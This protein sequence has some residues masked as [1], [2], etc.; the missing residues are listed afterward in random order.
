MLFRRT[1]E[2]KVTPSWTSLSTAPRIGLAILMTLSLM[3]IQ[4]AW[5]DKVWL[6]PMR[7]TAA[8]SNWYPQA[9]QMRVGE[10][11]SLDA[12]QIS[13]RLAGDEKESLFAAHRV[14][15]IEPSQRSEKQTAAIELFDAQKYDESLRGLLDSLKERPPVWRQQWLSML[16]AQAAWRSARAAIALELVAQLDRRPLPPLVLAWLPIAWRNDRGT[17]SGATTEAA[18]KRLADPAPAV[19][20]VAAS[21]LLSTDQR[22]RAVQTLKALRSDHARPEIAKLADVVLWRTTLPPEVAEQASRWQEK[23]DALPM[24]LQVGPTVLIVEQLSNANQEAA[25]ES[26]KLSLELTPPHPH[27]ELSR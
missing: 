15:W 27:P 24:V 3:G 8:Q 23:L 18:Q 26:L 19:R 7:P 11:I 4:T 6:E 21:W 13:I 9:I 16:A 14:I 10:I 5:G 25:A 2:T 22:D 12:K 1:T 20:L 17:S